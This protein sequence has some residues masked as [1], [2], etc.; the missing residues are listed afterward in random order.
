MVTNKPGYMRQYHKRGR[1]RIVQQLGGRCSECHTTDNIEIHHRNGC[2]MSGSGRGRTERLKD[3][4]LEIQ[5][6]GIILLCRDCH[7]ESEWGS[8]KK[9]E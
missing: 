8:R 4:R 6:N 5:I 7:Y 9:S 2:V 3:W 1:R